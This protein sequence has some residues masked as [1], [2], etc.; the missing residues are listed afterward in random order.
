MRDLA[1][2]C[3]FYARALGMEV[4]T[5]GEGRTALRFGDQKINVHVAGHEPATIAARPTPG[6]GDFCLISREPLARWIEHLKAAGVAVE[7]GPGRRTG[8]RGPIDSIYLRDPDG[9]LVEIANEVEAP[10]EPISPLRDWLRALQAAVRAR[11][12]AAGRALCVPE[13]I[14]FG[15][16]AEFVEGLARIEAEQWRHVWPAIRDFT[17][18]AD[19]AR[20]GIDGDRGWIAARWDSLGVRPD[21]STFSRPGRCTILF[22]RRDG[23]WLA[24][25]THFSLVPGG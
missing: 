5:F 11:D 24:T 10:A 7:Q 19:E 16:R 13:M 1:A 14:A 20:G 8:A 6:S 2:T 9:N 21:G 3:D 12:F 18:R 25:H 4:V 15:T 22:E 23:R 17:M